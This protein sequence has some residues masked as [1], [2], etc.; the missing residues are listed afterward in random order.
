M[1][2]EKRPYEKPEILEIIDMGDL[3]MIRAK[4][5]A[6]LKITRKAFAE[7]IKDDAEEHGR[8]IPIDEAYSLVDKYI[9]EQKKKEQ[10]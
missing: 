6:K 7:Y 9:E 1:S 5:Q 3:I 2:K 4:L 8:E 10:K